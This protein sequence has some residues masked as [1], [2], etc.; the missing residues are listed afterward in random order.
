M[1]DIR[2]SGPDVFLE[3][4]ELAACSADAHVVTKIEDSEQS[5]GKKVALLFIDSN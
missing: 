2:N 4:P 3:V 1:S 5:F